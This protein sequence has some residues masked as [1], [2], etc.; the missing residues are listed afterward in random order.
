MFCRHGCA[1]LP[2]RRILSFEV[3]FRRYLNRAITENF[4][5]WFVAGAVARSDRTQHGVWSVLDPTRTWA[6]SR[7]RSAARLRSPCSLF[8]I[9]AGS[10]HT[11]QMRMLT[12]RVISRFIPNEATP[13]TY[14]VYRLV[15]S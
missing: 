2:L 12:G 13:Q 15:M 5:A 9:G 8:E 7:F 10:A 14:E 1:S 11:F 6:Q 4:Q 3:A